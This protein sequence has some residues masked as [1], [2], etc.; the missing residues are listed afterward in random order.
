M[1]ISAKIGAIDVSTNAVRIAIVQT[2]RS[3]RLLDHAFVRTVQPEGSSAEDAMLSAVRQALD[4]L[5]VQP[6]LF[7]LL[8]RTEWSVVRVLRIPFRGRKVTDAVPFELEPFLAFP[9]EEL[10][11]DHTRIREVDNQTEVLVVGVRRNELERRLSVLSD[12]NVAIEGVALDAVGLT[13]LSNADNAGGM[14]AAVHVGSN[15][16]VFTVT[17]KKK[18][19]YIQRLP[20]ANE[21]INTEP[22]AFARTVH[23]AMKGFGGAAPG[24]PR[25]ESLTVTGAEFMEAGRTLFDDEFAVPVKH[26][27]LE[28]GFAI[29]AESDPPPNAWAALIGAASASAGSEN[30]F[31]FLDRAFDATGD[32]S[33]LKSRGL[34][35]LAVAAALL[36]AYLGLAAL[37]YHNNKREL[38]KVGAA[39]AEIYAELYP[40]APGADDPPEKDPGGN[41]SFNRLMSAV[42]EETAGSR[43][44]SLDEFTS[45][46]FIE[47]LAALAEHLPASKVTV[48]ELS[49]RPGRERVLMINGEL[50]GNTDINEVVAGLNQTGIFTIDKN[51]IEQRIQEGR[52]YFDIAAKL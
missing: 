37:D 36:L 30:R 15:E 9:I 29:E 33:D 20:V 47:I 2:G 17:Q 42:E 3:P 40:G 22:A 27:D 25:I 43:V 7:V 14:H 11:T 52:R 16:A 8:A 13:E 12:A 48:S 44:I 41:E 10:V 31:E 39:M 49:F 19:V 50:L 38:D 6:T 34:K 45:A 51:R 1:A 18:L 23:N 46:P 35:L 5:T 24:L 21:R 28:T 26:I 4:A 32:R